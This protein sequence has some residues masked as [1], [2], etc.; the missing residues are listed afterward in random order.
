MEDIKSCI[1][2]VVLFNTYAGNYDNITTEQLLA[3]AKVVRE[4]GNELLDAV[5]NNEGQEQ[6]LK[7]CVDV[8]VTITGFAT[9]LQRAGYDVVGAWEVIN[10]NNLSKFPTS[11]TDACYTVVGHE[12]TEL[13]S[14]TMTQ[15]DASRWAIKNSAGKVV[16]PIGYEKVSVKQFIPS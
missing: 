5:A 8:L 9:M 10:D 13:S 1:E 12:A 2:G 6:I 4:E 14:F 3:Q 15:V 7:E 16:K 11:Y